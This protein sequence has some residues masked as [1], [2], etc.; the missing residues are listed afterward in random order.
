MKRVRL[1][2]KRKQSMA[3]RRRKSM[4]RNQMHQRASM[5]KRNDQLLSAEF[6]QKIRAANLEQIRCNVVSSMRPALLIATLKS[7]IGQA[8][9]EAFNTQVQNVLYLIHTVE[10]IIE[11]MFVTQAITSSTE[12]SRAESDTEDAKRWIAK[13]YLLF[14]SFDVEQQTDKNKHLPQMENEVESYRKEDHKLNEIKAEEQRYLG[15]QRSLLMEIEDN[16]IRLI[17]KEQVLKERIDEQSETINKLN[18][19]IMDLRRKMG[20]FP[21]RST[22]APM[23]SGRRLTATTRSH[24]TTQRSQKSTNI[25]VLDQ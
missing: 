7:K 3:E 19:Q 4:L 16:E 13:V 14:K 5:N 11:S 10:N 15:Q 18:R 21:T 6:R 2:K 20:A 9:R 24:L 1:S 25:L 22:L 12:V 23:I 17:A 8:T